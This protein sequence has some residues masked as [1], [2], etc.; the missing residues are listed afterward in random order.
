MGDS[1]AAL[2]AQLCFEPGLGK[3]TYGTGS[4]VMM[5]IGKQPLQSPRGLVTSVGFSYDGEIDYVFEGNIHCTGDTIK[6]LAD[7]LEVLDS[8]KSSEA[9][10]TAVEDNG[11]VY[12]VPAFAGLGA[13]YWN[14]K[15][16]ACI[17]GMDRGATKAH[18]VRAALEAIA[19]Q[20]KDVAD[21]MTENSGISLKEL[22]VDGGPTRNR[23]LMQ[24]QSDM[25]NSTIHVSDIEEASA[26]GVAFMAGL[27][28]GL[29]KNFEELN[30]LRK[31]GDMYQAKMAPEKRK[32]LYDGWKNAV[33]QI[34]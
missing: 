27:A 23:F 28:T 17:S 16:R 4:S 3:A 9:V 8:S 12:F 14:N 15:A 18:I 30:Q 31:T 24:F 2:F 32:A 20:I 19:Y 21:L 34:L 13:P 7:N 1:H 26:L 11:G 6:W 25:L 33:N 10:A 29:W 22:R 5:N